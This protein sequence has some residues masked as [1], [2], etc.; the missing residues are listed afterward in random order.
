MVKTSLS[1]SLFTVKQAHKVI[2]NMM[3]LLGKVIVTIEIYIQFQ[4]KENIPFRP[5]IFFLAGIILLMIIIEVIYRS[6]TSTIILEFPHKEKN[7]H[8][9]Y[10]KEIYDCL[11]KGVE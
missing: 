11:L 1:T 7:K 4:T 6:Q 3:V 8:E 2:G 9:K 5:W 10:H